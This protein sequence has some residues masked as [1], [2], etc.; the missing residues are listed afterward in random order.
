MQTMKRALIVCTLVAAVAVPVANAVDDRAPTD[1]NA[2]KDCT[3]QRK[4]MRAESVAAR[5]M[6]NRNKKKARCGSAK[7]R[8]ERRERATAC[9]KLRSAN[10]AL[11]GRT[12]KSLGQCVNVQ[13]AEARATVAC[14]QQR[15]DNAL[16]FAETHKSLGRCVKAE[17]AK[18]R[19]RAA[20]KKPRSKDAAE[21]QRSL[22]RRGRC[23]KED[24]AG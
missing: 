3:A 22:Q 11:F 8:A 10:A 7:A 23:V 24:K 1:K 18:A 14:K 15:L 9:K 19:A 2:A 20:C 5:A 13:R 21:S 12:Y 17:T 6:P 16:T 4:S